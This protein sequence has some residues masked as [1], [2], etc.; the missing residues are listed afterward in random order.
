[1]IISIAQS[2]GGSGLDKSPAEWLDDKSWNSVCK[3]AEISGF[4]K[5]TEDVSTTWSMKFK[6]WFN[7]IS[8]EREKIPGD[9]KQFEG[10]FEQILLLRAIRP[11]RL[12][13]ILPIWINMHLGP[14]FTDCDGT[15]LQQGIVESS[16][17]DCDY[18][19]PMM[20]VNAPGVN[21]NV[22]VRNMRV[23]GTEI[24]VIAMGENM[25]R[26]AN[27]KIEEGKTNGSWI[28]L[29]NLHL[30]VEWMKEL[31]KMLEDLSSGA[32]GGFINNKFRLFLTT[33]AT[34]TIPIA[35]MERSVLIIVE[36]PSGIKPNMKKSWAQFN[37]EKF[38]DKDPKEK[39][40]LFGL[41]YFHSMMNERKKFGKV[42][43]N[44]DYPFNDGDLRDC[45]KIL[46]KYIDGL[47][48]SNVPWDDLK[49][50]FGEIMYGGH[51]T[52]DFDRRMCKAYLDW[53]MQDRLLDEYEMCPFTNGKLFTFKS[54][55]PTTYKA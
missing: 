44:L 12:T 40:I 8:P 55:S 45:G 2:Q 15:M 4:E 54:M 10:R 52:D 18:K 11:D 41:C 7:E 5:L 42:G 49:Y 24:E 21:P 17:D 3:L 26:I 37:T 39:N 36:P 43:Y 23:E 31:S 22:M 16:F 38:N 48:S 35:I 29:E 53:V 50:L 19:K 51:I 1:M 13:S 46:N 47:V 14:G 25:E 9:Y 30:M 28:M 32:S 27:N 20:F 34:D 6:D 33:D